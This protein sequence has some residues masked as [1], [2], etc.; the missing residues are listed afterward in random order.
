MK[1]IEIICLALKDILLLLLP[2]PPISSQITFTC[3]RYLLF[4][5]LTCQNLECIITKS[6]N[7]HPVLSLDFFNKFWSVISQ[8]MFA[9][10]KINQ[11]EHEMYSYLEWQLN[12]DLSQLQDIESKI[13]QNFKRP[14]PYPN[15]VL[16]SLAPIPMPSTI[17]Y[18]APSSHLSL[19]I[20]GHSPSMSPTKSAM[21]DLSLIT[22]L[23]LKTDSY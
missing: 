22:P 4:P 3:L 16:P 20:S 17:L 11:I 5:F 23:C 1:V 12:V 18:A 10:R 8:S 7:S 13:Q 19:F 2:Y 14:C 21:S 9:L 6:T 15:Y